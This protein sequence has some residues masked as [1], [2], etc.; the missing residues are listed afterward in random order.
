MHGNRQIMGMQWIT[1]ECQGV[2]G[3]AKKCQRVLG[4]QKC[5]RFQ[6]MPSAKAFHCVPIHV[7]E[8]HNLLEKISIRKI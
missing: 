5:A 1:S 6:A 4:M 3:S 7:R 2:I 8:F